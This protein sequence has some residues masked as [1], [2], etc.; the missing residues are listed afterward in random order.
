MLQEHQQVEDDNTANFMDC[1]EELNTSDE[2]KKSD[3]VG[4]SDK[5]DEKQH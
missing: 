3:E 1:Q 4:I 5:E 2:K